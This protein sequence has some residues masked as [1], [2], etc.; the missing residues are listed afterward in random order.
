MDAQSQ[1]SDAIR[2][3][4]LPPPDSIIDDG[5]LHRFSSN[6]KR[7]DDAGWYVLFGGDIPAGKVRNRFFML[8]VSVVLS[9]I[10]SG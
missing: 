7:S 4:G 9:V 2:A 5:K 8:M 3:S 10:R 1:F 6:G